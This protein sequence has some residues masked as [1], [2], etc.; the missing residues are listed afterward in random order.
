[1]ARCRCHGKGACMKKNRQ[2]M[3]DN[4]ARTRLTQRD[5]ASFSWLQV[6]RLSWAIAKVCLEKGRSQSVATT[7][8]CRLGLS[9]SDAGAMYAIFE[10]RRMALGYR[11]RIPISTCRVEKSLRRIWK[12]DLP[13]VFNDP[14]N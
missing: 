12:L 7:R 1:V 10:G 14:D 9:G 3:W 13:S 2:R 5:C 8:I 6:Y 11:Y 4:L